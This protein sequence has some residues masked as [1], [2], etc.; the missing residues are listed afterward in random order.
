MRKI[1]L[2]L[3]TISL[4]AFG[5]KKSDSTPSPSPSAPIAPV[6]NSDAGIKNHPSSG[7]ISGYTFD[8][9]KVV[10]PI[11]GE[12]LVYDY[13]G[14]AIKANITSTY[15]NA[16]NSAYAGSTSSYAEQLSFSSGTGPV[17]TLGTNFYLVNSS[18]SSYM[19][20][21]IAALTTNY[22]SIGGTV[23]Y[24]NQNVV[25]S[26]NINLA[27][28]PMKYADTYNQK[29]SSKTVFT[30]N[31]PAAGIN[32]A[33]GEYRDTNT[34]TFDH[35]AWGTLKLNGYSGSMQVLVQKSVDTAKRN[36]FL[37]LG[38]GMAPAPASV[39]N[40]LGLTDGS[41]VIATAY[42]FWVPGKGVVMF[43][44][45]NGSGTVHTGL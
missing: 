3:L 35:F 22:P 17:S 34:I 5:C 20:Y 32:N 42:K 1:I 40:A 31:A 29:I 26:P 44:N 38:A 30:A 6:V 24:P 10:I 28:F 12:N 9:N 4:L 27:K 7:T 37:N 39:L 19:G 23:S 13:S 11:A 8:S 15:G 33:A 41:I 45:S 2:S 36:Y 18:V 21:S 14:L 16:I 25:Y 43:V